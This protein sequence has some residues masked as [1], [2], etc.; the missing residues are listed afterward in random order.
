MQIF[1]RP[2]YINNRVS[3][4]TLTSLDPNALYFVLIWS[5][6]YEYIPNLGTFGHET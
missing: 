5:Q 1:A 2:I 3:T 4:P 6:I